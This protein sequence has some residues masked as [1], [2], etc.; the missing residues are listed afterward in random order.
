MSM[1]RSARQIHL[2]ASLQRIDRAGQVGARLASRSRPSRADLVA[3]GYTPGK[4]PLHLALDLPYLPITNIDQAQTVQEAFYAW[5]PVKSELARLNGVACM[6]LCCRSTSSWARASRPRRSTTGRA[7]AC[8]PS[9][10]LGD[11]MQTLGAVPT[12]V[13]APEVYTG[14]E[15]DTF[16]GGVISILVFVCARTSSTKC[17]SG[18]RWACSSA[19]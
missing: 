16:P 3:F 5:E 7:C 10:R 19:S 4:V 6:R 13:P 17:R 14:L 9:A 1:R 18:T 15:R 12:S 2:Q 8:A 11:A